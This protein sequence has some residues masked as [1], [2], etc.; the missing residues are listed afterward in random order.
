MRNA[1][2]EA[3]DRFHFL[4]L[5]RPLFQFPPFGCIENDNADAFDLRAV[6]AN[7]KHARNTVT[8]AV[9]GNGRSERIRKIHDRFAC[10]YHSR[11]HG[12]EN[13]G[14]LRKAFS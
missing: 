14:A 8:L 7:G 3:P 10:R 2:G 9:A 12:I 11:H 6:G 1:A 4:A 13:D 5:K